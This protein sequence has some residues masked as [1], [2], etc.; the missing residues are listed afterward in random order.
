MSVKQGDDSLH[1][2]YFKQ[3]RF[4]ETAD[5]IISA[6]FKGDRIGELIGRIVEQGK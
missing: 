5:V 2:M 6:G 1:D 4:L 3:K